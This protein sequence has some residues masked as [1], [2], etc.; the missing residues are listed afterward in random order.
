LRKRRQEVK[1]M[2]LTEFD[3][4]AYE[5]MIREEGREEG[6]REGHTA[7]VQDGKFISLQNLIENGIA[8]EEGMR[9]LKFTEAEASA[10]HAWVENEGKKR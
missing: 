8:E 1:D 5:A 6:M 2:I 9:L 3:K 10:Y 4:D 7:G